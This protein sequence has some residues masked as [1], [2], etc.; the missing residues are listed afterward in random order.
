MV[1]RTDPGEEEI[2]LR[3]PEL[4]DNDLQDTTEERFGCAKKGKCIILTFSA[5]VNSLLSPFAM[6]GILVS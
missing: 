1:K 3:L 6:N 5:R 2:I 4:T